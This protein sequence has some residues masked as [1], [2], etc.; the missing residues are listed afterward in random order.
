[1][2]KH[3][4]TYYVFDSSGR[5]TGIRYYASNKDEASKLF[6]DDQENYKKYG[7]YGKLSRSYN[8]GVY[9]STGKTY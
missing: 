9:G 3:R 7:S 6:K 2:K 8:G 1:M 5:D 4:N